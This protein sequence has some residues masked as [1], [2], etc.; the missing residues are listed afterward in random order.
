MPIGQ[1]Q[2]CLCRSVEIG[3]AFQKEELERKHRSQDQEVGQDQL[4]EDVEDAN[5][6]RA[7]SED[8]GVADDQTKG[9]HQRSEK[10][11]GTAD[12]THRPGTLRMI[13]GMLKLMDTE[14]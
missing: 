12:Q 11:Q 14:V 5:Q 4:G 3:R 9:G 8:E 7:N 2:D 13:Q 1:R 10:V 6:I